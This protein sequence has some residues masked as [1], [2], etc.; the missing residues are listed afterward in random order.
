MCHIIRHCSGLDDSPNYLMATVGA[1]RR[2]HLLLGKSGG[3]TGSYVWGTGTKQRHTQWL[4]LS[5]G[6]ENEE[7]K[8]KWVWN[9]LRPCVIT[10]SH[11][12]PVWSM[13]VTR[14]SSWAATSICAAGF[15]TGATLVHFVQVSRTDVWVKMF[16]TTSSETEQQ[17]ITPPLTQRL[18]AA[19]CLYIQYIYIYRYIREAWGKK[20]LA[21]TWSYQTFDRVWVKI[22]II[23]NWVHSSNGTKGRAAGVFTWEKQ[24]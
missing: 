24:C 1:L 17:S 8:K 18:C 20:N 9:I 19:G 4:V 10:V 7:F 15:Y 16:Y 21:V 13:G 2:C 6:D 3:L 11:L 14:H 5:P 22:L 23:N 12:E